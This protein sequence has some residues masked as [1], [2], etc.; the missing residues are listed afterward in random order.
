MAG[1]PCDN[2][3][4][5]FVGEEIYELVYEDI[6]N[7]E[8]RLGRDLTI[9]ERDQIYRDNGAPIP[10]EMYF[11]PYPEDEDDVEDSPQAATEEQAIEATADQT[12]ENESEYSS[13]SETIEVPFS[14]EALSEV[15]ATSP[16][17]AEYWKGL[18][19][20]A[21]KSGINSTLIRRK[22]VPSTTTKTRFIFLE[23]GSDSKE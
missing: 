8:K 21:Q 3:Q 11:G 23:K 9:K 4:D 1:F 5:G 10:A 17:M 20:I 19:E 15:E 2:S 16:L 18:Q 22:R 14:E 13:Q 7:E 6:A 12:E